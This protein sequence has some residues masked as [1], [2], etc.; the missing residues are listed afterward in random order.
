MS[1]DTPIDSLMSGLFL[2]DVDQMVSAVQEL[3][4]KMSE[5]CDPAIH[6]Q[7]CMQVVRDEW[8]LWKSDYPWLHAWFRQDGDETDNRKHL[9]TVMTKLGDTWRHRDHLLFLMD[10]EQPSLC[11][12]NCDLRPMALFMLAVVRAE[13]LEEEALK[14]TRAVRAAYGDAG[15]PSGLEGLLG[16]QRSLLWWLRETD[17]CG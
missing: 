7:Q 6:W 9:E 10:Q 3:A 13:E 1:A 16:G 15:L 8:E 11:H 17:V 4:S 2:E 12:E 5:N 14:V